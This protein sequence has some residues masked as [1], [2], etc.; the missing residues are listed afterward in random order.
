MVLDDERKKQIRETFKVMLQ[1]KEVAKESAQT[2]ND[3][4]KGL[5]ESMSASKD[6]RKL[7]SKS[8]KKA[9][10]EYVDEVKGEPDTFEDAMTIIGAVCNGG[11]G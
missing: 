4:L 7:I 8:L 1:Y 3:Q 5:V 10:V 9:F 11:E 6:E 2:A